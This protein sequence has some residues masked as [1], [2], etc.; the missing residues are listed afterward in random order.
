[1][2][3]SIYSLRWEDREIRD[4]AQN[5]IS[6]ST[7]HCVYCIQI[8]YKYPSLQSLEREANVLFDEIP[9]WLRTAWDTEIALY[10]GYSSNFPD[11][12]V[13]HSVGKLSI[14]TH[15]QWSRLWQISL[16]PVLWKRHLIRI[17]Q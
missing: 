1:M 13:A 6:A 9:H 10:V 17:M 16:A 14:L 4:K 2:I 8:E 11:R 7:P 3:G 15:L 5:L 12:V